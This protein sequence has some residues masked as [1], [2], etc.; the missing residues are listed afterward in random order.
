M[1]QIQIYLKCSKCVQKETSP[2]NPSPQA[3]SEKL[4]S[5]F[6]DI[7]F[8]NKG[9]ILYSDLRSSF[10]KSD[11]EFTYATVGELFTVV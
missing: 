10:A 3:L 2:I 6:Y 7:D 9:Y 11:M 4:R 5:V 1:C 8:G